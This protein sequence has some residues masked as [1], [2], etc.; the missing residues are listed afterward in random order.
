VPASPWTDPKRNSAGGAPELDLD[1]GLRQLGYESFRVGQREAIEALLTEGHL[2]LVAPTGGGKS[3]T[4]QLPAAILRGTALVISPLISLMHDQVTA[5]EQRGIAASFLASTIEPREMRARMSAMARGR[6]KLVYVAPERLAFAGFRSLLADLD[7]SLVAVDEA[8]CI[9][10]WGHDFRPEYLQIGQALD[11]LPATR[12]L[13]CTA[14]ATPVVRDEI[15]ARLGLPAS[16]RQLLH[17]F[18][19]PNLSLRV[20]EVKSRQERHVRVD[21]ALAEALG[22]PGR[23]RGAAIVYSP[24]RKATEA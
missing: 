3:L 24:T 20:C 8:H 2:L 22:G 5:L 12:V 16:T 7:C 17:G 18:A 14:T 9:S 15:L 6:Y 23:G 11:E 21:A 10:E 19:R 13:A 1:A 4:Y